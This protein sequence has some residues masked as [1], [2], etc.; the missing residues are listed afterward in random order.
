MLLKGPGT[1]RVNVTELMKAPKSPA[2]KKAIATIARKNNI[3]PM[4]AQFMQAR[5]IAAMQTRKK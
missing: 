2:R 1:V 4:D 5:K 3:K